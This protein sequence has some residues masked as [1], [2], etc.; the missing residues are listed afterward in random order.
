MSGMK[1]KRREMWPL[2]RP[3]LPWLSAYEVSENGDVRRV[4]SSRTSPAG[5]LLKGCCDSNGYKVYKL[6][7]CAGDNRI[8]KA[9]RLVALSFFGPAPLGR[10]HVAH[11]DGDPSNNHVTNLKWASPKENIGD[12]RRRHATNPAGERNPRAIL[13]EDEVREVRT[14]YQHIKGKRGAVA[15]LRNLYGISA[16]CLHGIISGRHWKHVRS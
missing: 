2:W 1:S 12:D 14:A 13:T 3:C 6:T 11:I 4:V 5:R 15:T 8:Y 9:H 10:S 7:R 16:G